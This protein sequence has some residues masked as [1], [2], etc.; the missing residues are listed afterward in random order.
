MCQVKVGHLF[1]FERGR[2]Q[3]SRIPEISEGRDFEYTI[4]CTYFAK[5]VFAMSSLNW[6][7]ERECHIFCP[8]G[9]CHLMVLYLEP[10][11]AADS[12][13]H[14]TCCSPP[15]LIILPHSPTSPSSPQSLPQMPKSPSPGTPTIAP[16]PTITSCTSWCLQAAS[17]SK[18]RLRTH[19]IANTP[20]SP[21]P[22]HPPKRN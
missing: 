1:D 15:P 9:A 12:E 8:L 22:P 13:S 3:S 10:R 2:N 21:L 20:H 14:R 5:E 19:C 6:N 7:I 18:P 17:H 11:E 16:A 4:S